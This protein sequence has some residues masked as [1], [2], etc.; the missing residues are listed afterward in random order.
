MEQL[1]K[2]Y[3]RVALLLKGADHILIIVPA[4]PGPNSGRGWSAKRDR[5]ARS[6]SSPPTK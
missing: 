5:P 6:T 4:R 3:E 1:K 2:Y